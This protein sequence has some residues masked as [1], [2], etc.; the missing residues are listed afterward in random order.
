MKKPLLI[1]VLMLLPIVA[2]A[3][4]VEID[5]I[6]YRLYEGNNAE[7]IS[8]PNGY[9]GDVVI[10]SII[11][12][13]SADYKVVRIR[14]EA[15]YSNQ[16]LTSITF[17][18]SITFIGTNAFRDCINLSAVYI[19]DLTAWCNIKFEGSL[20]G[21]TNPLSYAH[22][23]YLKGEE[24]KELIIPEGVSIINPWAFVGCSEFVSVSIPSSV[25][26]I[27]DLSFYGC[28]NM[29]KIT[30]RNLSAWC[31]IKFHQEN[32]FN[33]NSNPLG[34]AGH[35]Y[36]NDEEITDFVLPDDVN[37]INSFVLFG[38]VGLKS[39][40]IHSGVTAIGYKSFSS[41]TNLETIELPTSLTKIGD[42]A[43]QG[44]KLLKSLSIPD[45][46]TSIGAQSFSGCGSL[47]SLSVPN[48]ITVIGEGAFSGCDRIS[49]VTMS[50]NLLNIS[51]SLFY[52][53]YNLMSIEFPDCVKSIGSYAFEGCSGLTSFKMPK[54]VTFIGESAFRNCS[55]LESVDMSEVENL[56]T[57]SQYAF[58]NCSELKSLSFPMSLN[59]IGRSSFSGCSGLTSV[60]VLAKTPSTAENGAF[61]TYQTITLY[62][63]KGSKAAYEVA[64]VWK[65]FS[66]IVELDDPLT[67]TAND[68]TMVYGDAVPELTYKAEGVIFTGTPQITCEV[69]STSPVGTYPIEISQGTIDNN[70]GTYVNGTLTI[71]KAPLTI[72]AKNY[73]IKQGD[74]L[75]T[76]EV[77]YEGFRNN[78]TSAVL[79]KQPTITT[80]ATS[81]NKAGVYEINASGAEAQ[82]YDIS[83]SKGKL[84]IEAVEITPITET[85]ETSISGQITADTDLENAVIDNTYYN[86]K[87]ANGDGYNAT[88]RALVLNSTTTSEQMTAIQNAEVGDAAIR[89]NYSGVIFEI[90]AGQGTVTVDTK[91][92]GTHVLNVQIGNGEPNKITKSE[93]G[94]ADVSY[95]VSASAY[96]YLYA[97]T[98]GGSETRLNRGGTASANSVLLYGYK[99]TIGGTGIN[100]I[101]MEAENGKVFDLNGHHVKTPGKGVYI[102]N[103]QKVVIK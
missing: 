19:S 11:T 69:T 56:Q 9:K 75:P 40:K 54:N 29:K 88:E 79:T 66:S 42:E 7:V 21:G 34:I 28:N 46:V 72:T 39:V 100:A 85:E 81:T 74:A 3:E 55:K 27:W 38:C 13:E 73:T 50:K 33:L 58:L 93:R 26:E 48:S 83:Y 30:I 102:I 78:E 96:V 36:L 49:S 84:T 5:G 51:S 20:Y 32:V 76:F 65:D 41:C 31:N 89:E 77:T 2:G 92:I 82:N 14:N 95:D 35:L 62:V 1:F 67:V 90:P 101:R 15:F 10:P 87:A 70:N 18:N 97:S 60:K 91:T 94:T 4:E 45:G 71:T 44:C 63:P 43:F 8:K 12:F 47:T 68:L 59:Y 99:V 37:E 80:N 52:G 53:C 86:V 25:T 6:N 22:H 98:S 61:P 57:I 64:D 23:L 24:I 16:E 103:G 17:P